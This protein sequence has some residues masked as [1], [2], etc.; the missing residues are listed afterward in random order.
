VTPPASGRVR[1]GWDF[2]R[3]ARG[4]LAVGVVLLEL[5]AAVQTFMTSTLLPVIV[6]GLNAQRQLRL[7][8]AGASIGMFIGLPA[9][10]PAIRRF[11]V[12]RTVFAALC[13]YLGGTVVTV[14]AH[15]AVV[16][17]IGGLAQGAAAGVLA[18]FGFGVVIRFFNAE[19]RTRLIAVSSAVWIAPAL[20][21]PPVALW[22]DHLVG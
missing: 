13:G 11:G 12:S 8:V 6:T 5:G 7:L 4:R 15:N 22:L 14:T 9:A 19:L 10:G 16:F 17:A 18:V 3:S 1:G 21:G 2:T 20:A